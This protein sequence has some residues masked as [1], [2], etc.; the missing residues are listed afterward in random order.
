M[1][2]DIHFTR[3][4]EGVD[5]DALKAALCAD[6]FDNG[7]T[8][9]QL[10]RSFANSEAVCFAWANGK[11]IGKARVLSDGVCNAYLVDVWTQ[12]AYRHRGIA[13]EMLRRLLQDLPGQH[14]Y[15]QADED[16][17]PFYRKLGFQEQPHGLSRVIGEWLQNA[18]A[19]S[20]KEAACGTIEEP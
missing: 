15:L 10:Q 14:V 6:Q 4:L 13:T 18:S 7:R 5:W 12:S 16:V 20:D 19:T 1:E 11:I 17:V 8:P 9:E 3:T 2:S